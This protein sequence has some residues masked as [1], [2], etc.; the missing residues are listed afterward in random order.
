MRYDTQSYNN[1]LENTYDCVPSRDDPID[2]IRT[3]KMLAK[4]HAQ[5]MLAKN[6]SNRVSSAV[7][8]SVLFQ[9]MSQS[10][11]APLWRLKYMKPLIDKKWVE[12][13]ESTGPKIEHL[14]FITEKGIDYYIKIVKNR[15]QK[16]LAY[17]FDGLTQYG[18]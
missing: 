6:S 18:T 17:T 2:V 11:K 1:S 10:V 5:H 9:D 16:M 4:L 15:L 7:N 12:E 13:L 14:Y 8:E 3:D